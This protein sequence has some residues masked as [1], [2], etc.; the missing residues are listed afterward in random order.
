MLWGYLAITFPE[1]T[2]GLAA[3]FR[4]SS[5]AG[6]HTEGKA[7]CWLPSVSGD[8]SGKVPA[9]EYQLNIVS[10]N[11]IQIM[12][13]SLKANLKNNVL[14]SDD[15]TCDGQRMQFMKLQRSMINIQRWLVRRLRVSS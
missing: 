13:R 14:L 12:I 7:P 4:H 15:E 2:A 6:S 9:G 3:S 8:P 11:E 10:V 1:M 5:M